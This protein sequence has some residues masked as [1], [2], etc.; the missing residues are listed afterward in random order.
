MIEEF[1]KGSIL[2]RIWKLIAVVLCWKIGGI[3]FMVL[4]S[5]VFG[6]RKNI[7]YPFGLKE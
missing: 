1:I 2:V 6:N 4:R 7:M 5:E 3:I